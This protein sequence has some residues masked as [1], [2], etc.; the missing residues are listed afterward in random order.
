[1]LV[2]LW[3]NLLRDAHP[4]PSEVFLAGLRTMTWCAGSSLFGPAVGEFGSSWIRNAFRR[5]LKEQTFALRSPRGA[6]TTL[7]P[8]LNGE[9]TGVPSMAELL[10][11]ATPYFGVNL[12]SEYRDIRARRD[13]ERE[14]YEAQREQLQARLEKAL[15][16]L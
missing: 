2:E 4:L 15:A 13:Q 10:Y 11:A 8:I 16:K 6:A 9:R 7:E 14:V 5:I 12:S 3:R 1:M